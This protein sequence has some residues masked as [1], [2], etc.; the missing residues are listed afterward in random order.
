MRP[1]ELELHGGTDIAGP[2]GGRPRKRQK[3]PAVALPQVA[4]AEP[5]KDV[6]RILMM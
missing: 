3:L 5:R 2:T 4:R 6:P 1:Q